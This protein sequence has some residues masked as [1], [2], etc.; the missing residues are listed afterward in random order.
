MPKDL[1]ILRASVQEVL[2]AYLEAVR[3]SD[4][5]QVVFWRSVLLERME[6]VDAAVKRYQRASGANSDQP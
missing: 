3:R 4:K 5:D 1:S 2:Q 6:L